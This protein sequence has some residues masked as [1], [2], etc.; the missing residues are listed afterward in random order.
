VYS[1]R[2][3][4]L[5]ILFALATAAPQAGADGGQVQWSGLVGP[6]RMTVFTQP[7]PLR[8]GAADFSVF[9]QDPQTGAA[10]L[11]GRVQIDLTPLDEAGGTVSARPSRAAATNKLLRA[12]IVHLPAAGKYRALVTLTAPGGPVQ[13]E[14]DVEAGP[15]A[16]PW[17]SLLPWIVWPAVPI[18]LYVWHTVAAARKDARQGRAASA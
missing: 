14:F 16:P 11:D 2:A 13:A 4:W 17:R 3:D 5:P 10:V 12:A 1:T 18:V 15:P 9:V 8:A 7:V 6:Y